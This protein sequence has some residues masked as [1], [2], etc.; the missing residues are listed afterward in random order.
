[1]ILGDSGYSQRRYLMTPILHAPAG[2]PEEHYTKR[3]CVARNTV[4][5]TIGV[6]KNRWR[7]LLGHRVLHYHPDTAARIINA[8]CVLHNVCNKAR[9]SQDDS[10]DTLPPESLENDNTQEPGRQDLPELARGNE[11]RSRLV[12]ELWAARH[13]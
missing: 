13:F 12:H 8:C 5:R 2:S 11:A 7:C 6:L 1:M 10:E 4:E 3:H 9:L